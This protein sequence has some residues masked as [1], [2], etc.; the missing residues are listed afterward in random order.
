MNFELM[1]SASFLLFTFILYLLSILS[2]KFGEVM[3]MKKY[4][5]IYY[6]GIFFTFSG[7]VVMNLSSFVHDN[8]ILF[9]YGFFSIGL[10]LGLFASVKYWGWLLKEITK[11]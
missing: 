6:I 10:T 4:Y 7:S 1:D 2:R 5:Y 3:G 8:A 9:G 11:G